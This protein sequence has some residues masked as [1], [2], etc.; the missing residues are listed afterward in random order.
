MITF[1]PRRTALALMLAAGL[2]VAGT[3]GA[4]EPAAPAAP[5]KPYVIPAGVPKYVR[6]AVESKD[7]TPAMTARDFDRK[8][9]E[10]LE[11]GRAH[12]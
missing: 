11:I 1:K 4:A 8:P 7:R 5:P 10:L 6:D 3:A 9:A 12:V 2:A